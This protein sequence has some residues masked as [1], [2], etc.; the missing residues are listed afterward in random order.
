[1]DQNSLHISDPYFNG[2]L[3]ESSL[4]LRGRVRMLCS[5]C[6]VF[7]C[8]YGTSFGSY[9][10]FNT[11]MKYSFPS[12][13]PLPMCRGLYAASPHLQFSFVPYLRLK[14]RMT[15]RRM[16]MNMRIPAITP[17]IFTVP[18]TCFSG[19]MASESWVEAPERPH[20][21]AHT[22]TGT[23]KNAQSHISGTNAANW[24]N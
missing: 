17:A 20:I 21:H 12:T 23:H 14:V 7:L 18:S 9:L 13:S 8:I 4:R 11:F 1:M 19:S 3:I 16:M 22:N 10:S 24:V 2:E 15:P 5:L 6:A